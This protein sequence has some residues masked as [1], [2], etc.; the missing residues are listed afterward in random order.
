MLV[1]N[2]IK[3]VAEGANMPTVNE[4]VEVFREAKVLFG[5]AK[6][7]NAG[8]V[9]VSGLEMSQNSGAH[10]VE[11]GRTTENAARH[12]ARHSWQLPRICPWTAT[13]M[14]TTP[15]APTSPASRKWPTRCWPSASSKTP[16]P[17][18]PRITER[19]APRGRG[20]FISVPRQGDQLDGSSGTR[21]RERLDDDRLEDPAQ[22]IGVIGVHGFSGRPIRNV[23]HQH[24][25]R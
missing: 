15:R 16:I 13:A 1:K 14:S 10:V 25:A 2:G 5:P 11:R 3:A 6:A 23:E 22:R 19:P 4:G 7:A 20:L 17:R 8:G 24:I 12:H 18:H 9:A 21:C